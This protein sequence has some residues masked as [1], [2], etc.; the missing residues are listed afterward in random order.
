MAL[1]H[2]GGGRYSAE[3]ICANFFATLQFY[4]PGEGSVSNMRHRS[5]LAHIM[6]PFSMISHFHFFTMAGRNKSNEEVK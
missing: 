3:K 5:D 1:K 6:L 4:W 2:W